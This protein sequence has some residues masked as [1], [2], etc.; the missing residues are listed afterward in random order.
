MEKGESNLSGPVSG[1][2][3]GGRSARWQT[4]PVCPSGAPLLN[5]EEGRKMKSPNT[6]QCHLPTEGVL[7]KV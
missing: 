1:E 3:V 5:I 4:L 7:R 2:W 6:I